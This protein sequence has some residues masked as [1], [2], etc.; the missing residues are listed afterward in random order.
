[1]LELSNLAAKDPE[2]YKYLQEND[3]ELLEFNPE[4]ISE[5]EI[6]DEDIELAEEKIPTLTKE[7]LRQWQKALLG[8]CGLPYEL[9]FPLVINYRSVLAASV[10]E[11]ASKTIDCIPGGCPHERG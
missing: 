10:I 7:H 8:V 5:G 3:R 4:A 9:S 1:M 11:G 6:A 2:F